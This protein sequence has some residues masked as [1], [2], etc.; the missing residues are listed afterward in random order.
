M[1]V[2]EKMHNR[3]PEYMYAPKLQASFVRANKIIAGS[4]GVS[5]YNIPNHEK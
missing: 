4:S 2:I 5:T 1:N 3:E